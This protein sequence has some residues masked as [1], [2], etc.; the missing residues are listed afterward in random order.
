MRPEKQQMVNSIEEKVKNSQSFVLFNQKAISV[1]ETFEI[2]KKLAN[3]NS[4]M[5]FSP[6]KILLKTIKSAHGVTVETTTG[7]SISITCSS[8]D[9]LDSLKVLDSVKQQL[10]PRQLLN[11]FGVFV[12]GVYYEGSDVEELI[13]IP[14]LDVLRGQIVGLISAPLSGISG[15]I[16]NTLSAI[17]TVVGNKL[18]KDET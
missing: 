5:L 18:S 9:S 7:D 15:C 12:S 10:T 11:I 16:N 4:E 17:P 6:K 2:R 14:P 13:A 3:I 8:S 1:N